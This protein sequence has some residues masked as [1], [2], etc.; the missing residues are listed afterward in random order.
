MKVVKYSATWCGPC[1]RFAPV[2][3]KITGELGI[4]M[5][6]V[7]I[8]ETPDTGVMSVPTTRVYDKDGNLLDERQGAMPPGQFRE[9]LTGL[10]AA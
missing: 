6:S 2:A 3:E 5:E 7:D 1:K 9:W 8:D 4:P 10:A